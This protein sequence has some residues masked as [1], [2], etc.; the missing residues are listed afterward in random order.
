MSQKNTIP[1][2]YYYCFDT[3]FI[4]ITIVIFNHQLDRT[5]ENGPMI[6]NYC[7]VSGKHRFIGHIDRKLIELQITC[8]VVAVA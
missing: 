1:P 3:L 8:Y 7:L 2:L 4:L 5:I 6:N